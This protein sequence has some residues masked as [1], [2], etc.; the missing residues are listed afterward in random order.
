[1]LVQM[2]T[3]LLTGVS[4]AFPFLAP[5]DRVLFDAQM[6]TFY[7]VVYAASFN[8]A[9]HALALLLRIMVA[10]KDV[11]DRFYEKLYG[12]MVHPDLGRSSKQALF[13]N[14]VYRAIAADTSVPRVRA[15]LKRLL[16]V[17]LHEKPAFACAAL[18]VVSEALRIHGDA[19]DAIRQ[20]EPVRLVGSADD[21][22][23]KDDDD[24]DDEKPPAPLQA[25]D[26][27]DEL[28]AE[29]AH[30]LQQLAALLGGADEPDLVT[31]AAGKSDASGTAARR[32]PGGSGPSYN[33]L[34]PNP[35]KCHADLSCAWELTALR[36]HHHPSVAQFAKQLLELTPIRYDGDPLL[37]FSLAAFLDRL[38]YKA[39]KQKGPRAAADHELK[40]QRK[41]ASFSATQVPA[42]SREFL[43]MPETQVRE[44]EKFIHRYMKLKEAAEKG[45]VEDDG[46][47]NGDGEGD[48][49]FDVIG[50]DGAANAADEAMLIAE[51][52]RGE[53]DFGDGL[54]AEGDEDDDDDDGGDGDDDALDAKLLGEDAVYGDDDDL[55]DL[56]DDDGMRWCGGC[57]CGY[58]NVTTAARATDDAYA[59]MMESDGDD[60]DGDGAGA[61][62]ALLSE[63]A[64]DGVPVDGGNADDELE[65]EGARYRKSKKAAAAASKLVQKKRGRKF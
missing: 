37:D 26:V 23:D 1:M 17:A 52:E 15:F 4:R 45:G 32:R 7:R 60:E 41:H 50:A 11:S 63:A 12:L 59:D 9:C 55:D 53:G 20:A 33:P 13:L 39:P 31:T 64:A 3:A 62:G 28:E 27:D 56:D 43:D 61:L 21:G 2:L 38:A 19:Q 29:R 8:K 51:Y 18:I 30:Q 40:F 5:E 35:L 36:E 25:A 42:D 44:E 24:G 6:D 34:T 47:D 46:D 65:P 49:D 14:V 48:D 22:D 57:A 54:G 16:Q 10:R 58:S